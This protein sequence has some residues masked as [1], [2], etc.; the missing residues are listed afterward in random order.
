M[1][2]VPRAWLRLVKFSPIAVALVT[3]YT[4][5]PHAVRVGIAVTEG[6]KHD[7]ASSS[8]LEAAGGNHQCSVGGD[9]GG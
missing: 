6:R 3:S 4:G 5:V 2:R 8:E 9:P 7:R 1:R